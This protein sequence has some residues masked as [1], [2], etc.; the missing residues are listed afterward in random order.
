[1]LSSASIA[2]LLSL[3]YAYVA[4]S[5]LEGKHSRTQASHSDFT[6]ATSAILPKREQD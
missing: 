3:R 6:F 1:M 5:S 4:F 2:D